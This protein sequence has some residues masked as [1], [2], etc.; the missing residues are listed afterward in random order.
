MPVP[1]SMSDL[2]T[3]AGSNSPA[4]TEVIGTSLDDYL[5]AGFA[6]IRS[7][8]ALGASTLAA[9]STTDIASVTAESVEVTGAATITSL[10][11]GFNG[12]RREV[13]FS[14]ACTLTHST[15]L[16]LPGSA[17]IT[18]AAGDV[19]TF[20]CIG[21]GQWILV[22]MNRTTSGQVTSALGYTPVNKA[23]D[24]MTGALALSLGTFSASN[25]ISL[26]GTFTGSGRT[27]SF[28]NSDT[29][30]GS[31]MVILTQA[32]SGAS[33]TVGSYAPT[34]TPLPVLADRYAI[35]AGGAGIAYSV[36][37]ASGDHRW[38]T[39]TARTLRMTLS[40]AGDLTVTGGITVGGGKKISKVTLS[41]ASPGV[42][43]D[44]ELYLKY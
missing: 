33:A 3:L 15:N 1:S 31:A 17:N 12:C 8:N 19:C 29:S 42:L 39:G 41:S 25:P 14:G 21:S 5:R 40:S 2:A 30:T 11:T 24:T 22:A 32:G 16:Q 9:A 43:A 13:R 10:G 23:G 28:V 36:N 18:T 6:I 7:T 27:I 26:T 38:H 34:Y 44:G 35:D 20:R 37:S 4:G